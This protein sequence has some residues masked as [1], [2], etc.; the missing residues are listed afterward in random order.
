M[1]EGFLFNEMAGYLFSRFL[2]SI[3]KYIFIFG[4]LNRFFY[5]DLHNYISRVEILN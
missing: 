3:K 1:Y 4:L 5:I 2:K